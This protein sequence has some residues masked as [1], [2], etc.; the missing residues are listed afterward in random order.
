MKDTIRV[1]VADDSPLVRTLLVS[2]LTSVPGFEIVGEAKDGEEAVRLTASLHPDVITM[3]IRMPRCDGLAATRMIKGAQ[4][5]TRIV[6]LTMSAEDDELFE[7]VAAGA[8]GYLLKTQ[9]TEEVFGLL[10]DVAR[11]EVLPPVVAV[12]EGLAGLVHEDGSL[13]AERVSGK[14]VLDAASADVIAHALEGEVKADVG[15]GDVA[16]SST[17]KR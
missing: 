8:S 17:P 3:D 4:P 13:A 6:M 7:A 15:S 2:M 16:S 12:H 5:E 14:I 9:D 11:G 1:L 10:Q